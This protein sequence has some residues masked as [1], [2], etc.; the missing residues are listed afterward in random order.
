M[1]CYP[2]QMHIIVETKIEFAPILREFL[3]L[4]PLPDPRTMT[5]WYVD[6]QQWCIDNH[7]IRPNRNQIAEQLRLLDYRQ[8]TKPGGGTR[9]V[10]NDKY[11]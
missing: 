5:D 7:N 11:T 6:C 2:H 1:A 4:K 3:T 8:T 10:K 9:W